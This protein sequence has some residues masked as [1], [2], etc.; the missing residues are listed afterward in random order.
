MHERNGG[1]ILN[2]NFY[3]MKNSTAF[4]RMDLKLREG[5]NELSTGGG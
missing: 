3:E 4:R 5:R 2:A 1:I